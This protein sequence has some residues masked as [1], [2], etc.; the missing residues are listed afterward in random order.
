MTGFPASGKS[1]FGRAL[2]EA[3]KAEGRATCLL[4]G[5]DVREAIEPKLGYDDADRDA[6]YATLASLAAL[7]SRQGLVV[8]VAAT[9]HRRAYRERASELAPAFVEVF[10]DVPL[11]ECRR[12]DEKGLY[13]GAWSGTVNTLPGPQLEYEAP[14]RPDVVARRGD[15]PATIAE[16]AEVV[17]KRSALVRP[18]SAPSR[19]R[20]ASARS[21]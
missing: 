15:D 13:D 5:D 21:A 20:R 11:G 17:R 2:V 7:L 3:L 9:A 1:T 18:T 8:V 4:D 16:V 10:V 12:R 14:E 6:F 19:G